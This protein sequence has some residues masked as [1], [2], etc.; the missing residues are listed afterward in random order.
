MSTNA[1]KNT[2]QPAPQKPG[3]THRFTDWAML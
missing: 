3:P 1:R 2:P